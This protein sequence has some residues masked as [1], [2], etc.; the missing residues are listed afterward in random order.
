LTIKATKVWVEKDEIY[1]LLNDENEIHFPMANNKKLRF[2]TQS[3]L[4]NVEIIA[5]GTGL[6]W[7]ELDEDLSVIG[8]MEG[9]YGY[10]V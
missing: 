4:A 8:I 6:H 2:A 1:I 10:S 9:R 3:Q 7:A 5:G